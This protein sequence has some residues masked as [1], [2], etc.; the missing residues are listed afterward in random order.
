VEV[1]GSL[2]GQVLFHGRG[3]G[4][5]PTASAVLGDL[6]DIGRRLNTRGLPV[7][8]A[9]SGHAFPVQS[10]DDLRTQYYIRLNV[11]DQ[12]GVL[13]QVAKI[14]GDRSIS[15]ASVLQKDTFPEEQKAELVV[16]T[17]PARD[18][19]VQEALRLVAGLDVVNEVSNM[20][21]IEG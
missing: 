5:G 11:A 2:C 21:R 17:H 15:I 10:I 14:L 6:I 4:R 13:A 19:S 12:A 9:G 7:S 18:A 16:T 3:A 1:T 20:L 8:V